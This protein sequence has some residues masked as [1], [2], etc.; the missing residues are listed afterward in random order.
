ML[1]RFPGLQAEIAAIRRD[2]HAHPELGLEELRTSDIVARKLREWNIETHPGIGQTG[3]V[4]V[5][6]GKRPGNRMIGLRADMDAL[7][8]L[9]Q[10][11]LPHA[12]THHGVMHACGHDGHTAMLLGAARVLAENPNFAGT[13]IL[14]FQPAE[15]GRGGAR[16]MVD[17]GLFDRFPCDAIYGLHNRPG[18]PVGQFANRRGPLM[19]AG[20]RWRVIFRGKGGHGGSTPHFTQDLTV[21]AGHFLLALQTIVSRNV[22]SA[23][24]AVLSVG[25]IIAGNL[26]AP[27]VMPAELLVAGV[28]RTFS[29]AT[30]L[31]LLRRIEELAQHLAAAHGCA[32]EFANRQSGFVVDNADAP[33]SVAAAAAIRTVGEDNFD[34]DVVRSTGGEDFAEMMMV[35]PGCMSLIGN[36]GDAPER[37]SPRLHTP[38]YDF[39]DDAIPYGVAFWC[40]VVQLELN[41][42]AG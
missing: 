32:A 1:D 40:N 12:S 18:L 33:T 27:A 17:D 13:V 14:I 41:G 37:Q 15:E 34:G 36:G 29:A 5:I 16:A 24:Q 23:E 30:R 42:E 20:D 6:R 31:T 38:L 39:N 22:P 9:E 7:P 4:G 19:A 8:I 21:V 2:I 35:V 11:G 10:S 26:D 3:V 28:C 25:H